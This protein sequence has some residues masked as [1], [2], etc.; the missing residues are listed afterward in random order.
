MGISFEFVGASSCRIQV[1]ELRHGL[2]R[3]LD[4]NF[5]YDRLLQVADILLPN[6]STIIAS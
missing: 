2:Y 1:L 6:Q 4:L 5:V 3:L